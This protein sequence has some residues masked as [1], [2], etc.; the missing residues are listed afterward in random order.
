MVCHSLLQWTTFC[1]TSPPWPDHLGWPHTAWLSLTEL[2]KA[3]V[4]WADWLV[5]VTVVSV[6]LPS[7]ALSQHLPSYLGFSY[8]RSGV[9][10]QGCSSKAQPL[11]LTLRESYLLTASPPDLERGVA[12]LSPPVPTTATTSWTWGSSSRPPPRPWTWGSSY[13]PLLHRRSLTLSVTAPDLGWGVAPHGHA[14]EAKKK[15]RY[16]R[17]VLPGWKVSNMLLGK[18]RG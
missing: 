4:M 17:W 8:L 6:C 1:Q 16:Q 9:S 11:L 13:R 10:L 18:S 14:K 5:S 15:K 12:P 2:D 7:D 3:V